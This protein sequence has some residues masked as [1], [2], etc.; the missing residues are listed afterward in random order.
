M[1]AI[2]CGGSRTR[3]GYYAPD[4]ALVSE[5][6]GGP[7][8]PV[9]YGLHNTVDQIS[10]LA[11]KLR[12]ADGT[13]IAVGVAGVRND[14]NREALWAAVAHRFPATRIVVSDDQTPVLLASRSVDG[15]T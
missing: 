13:H 5:S 15:A 2:D 4:G 6:E 12:I 9:A 8:N 3:A 1:L 11:K 14:E 10:R 7:A